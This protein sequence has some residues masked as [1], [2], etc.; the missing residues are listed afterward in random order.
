[1]KTSILAVAVAVAFFTPRLAAAENVPAAY[2]AKVFTAVDAVRV[3]DYKIIITGVV[4]GDAGSS[5]WA[6][7][8]FSSDAA[9]AAQF[10]SNCQAQAL[11]AMAKPGQY[12]LEVSSNAGTSGSAFCKLSRVNP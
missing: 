4:Q 3:E 12:L 10:L 9:R 2:P 7:S 11:L 8:P 5:T 1:M 6:V